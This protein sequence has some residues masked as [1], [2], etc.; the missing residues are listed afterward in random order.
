MLGKGCVLSQRTRAAAVIANFF[1]HSVE[2]A[3]RCLGSSFAFFEKLT[4]CLISIEACAS[5]HHRSRQLQALGHTVRLIP[6]VRIHSRLTWSSD[7]AK[8]A[9]VRSCGLRRSRV[10][11]A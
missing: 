8:D 4:P 1:H 2:F 9:R 6:P 10:S 5:S 3:G 7:H 11:S